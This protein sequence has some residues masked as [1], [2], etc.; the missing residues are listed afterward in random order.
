MG[1]FM[2]ETAERTRLSPVW[3]TGF[4]RYGAGNVFTWTPQAEMVI[5]G[6][7]S[8]KGRKVR[9]VVDEIMAYHFE[10]ISVLAADG[11]WCSE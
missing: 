8:Y 9:Y 11:I 10:Q 4:I 7:R 2:M 6:N 5:M 1:F 3:K